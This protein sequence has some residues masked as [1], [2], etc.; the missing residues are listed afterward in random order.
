[1]FHDDVPNYIRIHTCILISI[2]EFGHFWRRNARY[3][4][5]KFYLASAPWLPQA[6]CDTEY[7]SN[8]IPL[9]LREAGRRRMEDS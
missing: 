6:V 4:G 1:V 7:A 8:L 3:K 9:A 5:G 2:H